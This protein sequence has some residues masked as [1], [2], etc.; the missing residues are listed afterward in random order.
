VDAHWSPSK[1]TALV[2]SM[3]PYFVVL[4]I[5]SSVLAATQLDPKISPKYAMF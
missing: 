3:R 2:V 1:A 5:I 4:I